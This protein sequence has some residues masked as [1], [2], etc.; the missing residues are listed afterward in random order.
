MDFEFSTETSVFYPRFETELLVEKAIDIL[1]HYK[2]ASHLVHVLDLCTGS[3]N[4]AISLTKYIPLSRIVASDISDTA[5]R[6]ARA[7]IARYGVSD[8]IDVIK[9]DLFNDLGD[10]YIDFFDFII[11]NP[12]YI[13]L[14]EFNSLPKCVK[15]DP[16]IA[17]YGGKDGLAFY[18]RI[19]KDSAAY[20][21]KDGFLLMEIGCDQAK[22]ITHI[23]KKT[24]EFT[25]IETYKDYAGLNRIIKAK[26]NG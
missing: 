20:L 15:D 19:T 17:L 26:K 16:Y 4:I 10:G 23:L 24:S 12:P 3:G 13:S 8:R 9:S 7:N 6:V 11:T 1:L 18:R 21:K 22:D 25:D 5:L 2:K 14:K